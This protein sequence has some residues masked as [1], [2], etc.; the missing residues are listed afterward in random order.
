[1]QEQEAEIPQYALAQAVSRLVR[2]AQVRSMADAQET[3]S[4]TR[5]AMESQA[6]PPVGVPIQAMPEG[7]LGK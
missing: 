2:S 5:C 7:C 6:H 4:W 3:H 1:M